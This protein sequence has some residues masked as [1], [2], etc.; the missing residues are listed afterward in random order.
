MSIDNTTVRGISNGS[1]I[2][3]SV[4]GLD[5]T[6]DVTFDSDETIE[7]SMGQITVIED[8]A[9]LVHR[10]WADQHPIRAIT[11]LE[12]ALNNIEVDSIPNSEIEELLN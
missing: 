4:S 11:G 9:T 12:D 8:H 1:P 3:V 7:A 5:T 6:V 2:E 10:D